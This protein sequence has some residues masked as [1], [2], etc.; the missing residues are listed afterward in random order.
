MGR[1]ALGKRLRFAAKLFV[2]DSYVQHLFFAQKLHA[3]SDDDA[4]VIL[5]ISL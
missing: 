1:L 5:C 4:D 3:E 2:E